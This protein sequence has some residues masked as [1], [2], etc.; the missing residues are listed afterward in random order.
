[1][2]NGKFNWI[3]EANKKCRQIRKSRK[4][5]VDDFWDR[6]SQGYVNYWD[7]L[8]TFDIYMRI[9]KVLQKEKGLRDSL[10][11]ELKNLIEQVVKDYIDQ[12]TTE[13]AKKRKEFIKIMIDIFGHIPRNLLTYENVLMFDECWQNLKGLV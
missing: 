6:N 1:M 7:V 3:R 12:D 11:V 5:R 4:E 10:L 13:E 9:G 2:K 8:G